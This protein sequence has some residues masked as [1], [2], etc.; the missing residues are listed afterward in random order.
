MYPQL[1][2]GQY[3][4]LRHRV[5]S[6]RDEYNNDTYTFTEVKVGPCSVQQTDSREAT[7]F[8]DQVATGVLVF[9]PYGTDVEFLDAMIIDGI[10]YEIVGDPEGW[11]SPFSGHTAPVRV[12]GQ[13]VKGASP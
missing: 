6:G 13:V 7:N 4:T 11:V 5:V 10:E 12:I 2:N 3:V 9:M 1:L 8:T